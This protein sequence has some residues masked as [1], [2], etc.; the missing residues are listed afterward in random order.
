MAAAAALVATEMAEAVVA[1]MA[2]AAPAAVVTAAVGREL[3]GSV[4]GLVAA[5]AGHQEALPVPQG[6]AVEAV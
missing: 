3:V 1:A 6:A 4:R 2:A 5:S